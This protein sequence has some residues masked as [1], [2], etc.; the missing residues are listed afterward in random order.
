MIRAVSLIPFALACDPEGPC[1][2]FA[3]DPGPAQTCP[4]GGTVEDIVPLIQ[5]RNLEDRQCSVCG[6]EVDLV[7]LFA[8]PCDVEITAQTFNCGFWSQFGARPGLPGDAVGDVVVD[9]LTSGDN[10][11]TVPPHGALLAE[12]KPLV[13]WVAGVWHA[14][15]DTSLGVNSEATRRFC[16]IEDAET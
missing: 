6:P 16:V 13:A 2:D 5:V 12:R 1:A 11:Y 14:L 9:C 8:N 15:A 4:G 7:L 3:P 10:A